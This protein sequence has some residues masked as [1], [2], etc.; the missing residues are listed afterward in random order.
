MRSIEKL[1]KL[2]KAPST[3][4][5]AEIWLK[6]HDRKEILDRK[7]QRLAKAESKE[8]KRRLKK[9]FDIIEGGQ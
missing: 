3:K 6:C 7:K 1:N 9:V 2:V 8:E 5:I 4:R